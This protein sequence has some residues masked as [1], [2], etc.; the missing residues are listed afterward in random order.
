MIGLFENKVDGDEV[1]HGLGHAIALPGTKR[2]RITASWAWR[3]RR[4]KAAGLVD[5]DLLRAPSVPM[6]TRSTTLALLAHAFA[7]G[8]GSWALGLLR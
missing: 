4:S 2:Q 3:S 1:P 8:R 7:D 6:S 5:L